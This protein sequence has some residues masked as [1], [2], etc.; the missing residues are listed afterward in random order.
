MFSLHSLTH[1]VAGAG[2]FLK[3]LLT[4]QYYFSLGS[5]NY[6]I[7]QYFVMQS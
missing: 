7:F 1:I 2:S 4:F 3:Q 6:F 5:S